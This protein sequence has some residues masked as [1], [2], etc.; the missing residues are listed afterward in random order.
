MTN[1]DWFRTSS[2]LDLRTQLDHPVDRQLKI[3]ATF[4]PETLELSME[5]EGDL[6]ACVPVPE[7][8]EQQNPIWPGPCD[9]V[10]G[11]CRTRI[12][13]GRPA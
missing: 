6:P 13:A 8:H 2:N 4:D 11:R 1:M 7:L 3:P 5:V 9:L 12:R 10:L